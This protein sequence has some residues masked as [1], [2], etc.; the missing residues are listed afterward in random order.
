MDPP[1]GCE[2]IFHCH[3]KL[4]FGGL[5]VV[6]RGDE[7]LCS[8][9]K[10]PGETVMSIDTADHMSATMKINDGANGTV[11]RP[12]QADAEITVRPRYVSVF[13]PSDRYGRCAASLGQHL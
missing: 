6:N 4:V 3:W 1:Q 9:A 13:Y 11:V 5:V 2:R 12:V 8:C 7:R 10:T